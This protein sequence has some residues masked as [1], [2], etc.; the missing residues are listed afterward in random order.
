MT[1]SENINPIEENSTISKLKTISNLKIALYFFLSALV[2]TV[3]TA[4][5]LPTNSIQ[6]IS[7]AACIAIVVFL[8][9]TSGQLS[10]D[11]TQVVIGSDL[12][13]KADLYN[14][15]LDSTNELSDNSI[16]L[17]REQ[18]LKYC[19]ELIVDYKKTRKDSRNIYY[20][21]QLTT[22]IFSSITPVLILVDKLEAD[23]IWL[24]WLPII[25]PA[26]AAI[27]TS[28]STSFPFQENY[29]G[30]NT[31]VELLEAEQEKFIL[32]V[33]NLYRCYDI[34]DETQ[35]RNKL[36][37]TIDNFINQVNTIHLKQV[38]E[39]AQN[40]NKPEEENQNS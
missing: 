25:F 28:I 30:A 32:G 24:K 35:R 26:L 22:I 40:Q 29:I 5:L 12:S 4:V 1:N 19:Q 15:L 3:I 8:Y 6:I 16:N 37:Q 20:I 17:A 27:I 13:Q 31:T 33:S 2:F 14:S 39:A 9:F 36:K 7:I 18:A 10:Q 23:N 38:Q 11:S 21:S 34:T